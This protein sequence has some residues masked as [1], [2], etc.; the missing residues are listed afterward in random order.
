MQIV[1]VVDAGK[2]T[3]STPVNNADGTITYVESTVYYLKGS[4]E[5]EAEWSGDLLTEE[6]FT[7]GSPWDYIFK[8]LIDS[9]G[10]NFIGKEVILDVSDP[11]G[12]ILKVR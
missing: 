4:P 2:R 10:T 3:V 6:P 5:T 12:N 9:L 7:M 11:D 8:S 1:N